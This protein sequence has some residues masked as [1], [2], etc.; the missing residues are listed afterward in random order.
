MDLVQ[1][2]QRGQEANNS[3]TSRSLAF[4]DIP[5]AL[6]G[7]VQAASPQRQQFGEAQQLEKST[8]ALEFQSLSD[9]GEPVVGAHARKQGIYASESHRGRVV[10][11]CLSEP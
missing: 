9:G 1:T 3:R 6:Y 8:A 4:R 10:H 11:C 7:K 2:R 5:G